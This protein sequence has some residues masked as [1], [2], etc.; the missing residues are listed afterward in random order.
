MALLSTPTSASPPPDPEPATPRSRPAQPVQPVRGPVLLIM[1]PGSRRGTVRRHQAIAALDAHGVPYEMVETTGSGHAATV[2]AAR[3]GEFDAVFALGGDGTAMEVVGAL[4]GSGRRVGILPGGTGNLVA[5]TLGI[6][7]DVGRA[8]TALL[9]GA[10]VHIDLGVLDDGRRFAFTAGMGLDAEMIARTPHRW[11]RRLGVLAY[12]LTAGRGLLRRDTFQVRATV[13]GRVYERRASSVMVAN[14]GT[15]LD[16]LITLGPDIREDDGLLDL[17][18]FSPASGG[19]AL[20]T[21]WRLMRRDFRAAPYLLWVPGKEFRIETDPPR[22][23][24]ADGE[25]L[26]MAPLAIRV[27]PRAARLLVPGTA[28]GAR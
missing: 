3:A 24:Q 5:R 27:Q 7:L 14:F 9:A 13:D 2:A 8:V 23:A 18:I 17:C 4:A 19:Q 10:E 1:N 25:L 12:A 26:G 15:V 28:R 6:P 11:K 21:I 22:V 20:L 16:R